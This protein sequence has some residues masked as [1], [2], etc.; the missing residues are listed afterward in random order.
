MAQRE[1]SL[2]RCINCESTFAVSRI[3]RRGGMVI[4][5]PIRCRKCDA[6]LTRYTLE[7]ANEEARKR[8]IELGVIEPPIDP[9]KPKPEPID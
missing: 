8:M 3:Y 4:I 6:L 2:Y 9:L 1:C 5:H 7:P